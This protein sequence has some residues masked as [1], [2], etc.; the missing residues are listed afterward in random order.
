MKFLL[1]VLLIVF[2]LG[3]TSPTPTPSTVNCSLDPSVD[4]FASL[5]AEDLPVV[6]EGWG[7]PKRLGFNTDCWEDSANIS[8]DGKKLYFSQYTGLDLIGDFTKGQFSGRIF[9]YVSEYP[10]NSATRSNLVPEPFAAGGVNI[11]GNDMYYHSNQYYF[12][13]G[14]G[15]SDIY[16]NG[17]R[18]PWNDFEEEGDPYYCAPLDELYYWITSEGVNTIFVYKDGSKQKLPSPIN[19]GKGDMQPWLTPDCQ[20]MYFA[21]SR[22]HDGKGYHLLQIYRSTRLSENEWSEPEVFLSSN[23][24]VAEPSFSDDGKRMA[25]VQMFKTPK[26]EFILDV[27][28]ME[29][30]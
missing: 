23:L 21:S 25:F 11:S 24:A 4:S 22:G 7:T 15:D 2:L 26:G 16:K 18:L 14:K 10:F 17:E 19:S 8:P 6:P 1:V 3:C 30:E 29:R 28:S 13:D 9:D 5:R 27:Y 12:E 20:T